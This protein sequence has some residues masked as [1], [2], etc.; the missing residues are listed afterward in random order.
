ML[1]LCMTDSCTAG[2]WAERFIN[3]RFDTGWVSPMEPISHYSPS[4][5]WVPATWQE[6]C[7]DIFAL[8]PRRVAEI[9]FD[10]KHRMKADLSAFCL[11]GPDFNANH[12]KLDYLTGSLGLNASH[13]K[14]VTALCCQAD[15]WSH[16]EGIL[17]RLL[18][19]NEVLIE[20]NVY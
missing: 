5:I 19:S 20:Q 14:N 16:S 18:H 2:P 11:G 9:Y 4:R 15:P 10:L 7:P 3:L 8:V 6:F 1:F 17:G 12:C 13:A